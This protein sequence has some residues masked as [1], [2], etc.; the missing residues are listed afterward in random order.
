MEGCP[1]H[2]IYSVSTA[3]A[4]RGPKRAAGEHFNSGPGAG[5]PNKHS[6]LG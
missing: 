3:L 6:M 5:A 4:R 2:H 1:G